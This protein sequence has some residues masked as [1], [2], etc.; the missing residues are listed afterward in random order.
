MERPLPPYCLSASTEGKCPLG[1]G[2]A[3]VEEATPSHML[4]AVPLLMHP[5]VASVSLQFC[6]DALYTYVN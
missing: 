2:P 1:L 4:N 6:E 5:G 3:R